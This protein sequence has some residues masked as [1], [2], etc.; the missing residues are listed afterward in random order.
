MLTEIVWVSKDSIFQ[1]NGH[2]PS[3]C[4]GSRST[5]MFSMDRMSGSSPLPDAPAWLDVGCSSDMGNS[6]KQVSVSMIRGQGTI[7]ITTKNFIHLQYIYFKSLL[8]SGIKKYICLSLAYVV[9][10]NKMLSKSLPPSLKMLNI[11]SC[12]SSR[13]GRTS[14]V[15]KLYTLVIRNYYETFIVL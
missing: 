5:S 4:S 13:S 6:V 14:P 12:G 7:H 8:S 10:A 9:L 11:S 1:Q 3:A 2:W 15:I